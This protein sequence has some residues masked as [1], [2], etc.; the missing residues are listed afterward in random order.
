MQTAV[1]ALELP[2]SNLT[3]KQDT[4][5]WVGRV[6]QGQKPEQRSPKSRTKWDETQGGA[7][8]FSGAFAFRRK[9]LPAL[10]ITHL[11]RLCGGPMF[12]A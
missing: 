8:S 1:V 11:E 9:A 3:N 7:R 10:R 4:L 2:I 5:Y 6:G 12:L